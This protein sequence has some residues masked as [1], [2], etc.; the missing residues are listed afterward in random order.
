MNNKLLRSNSNL[1][2]H[3]ETN[4]SPEPGI[5]LPV[6]VN[7]GPLIKEY[8]DQLFRVIVQSINDHKRV[9]ACRFNLTLPHNCILPDDTYTNGPINRFHKSLKSKIEHDLRL[10]RSPHRCRVRYARAREISSNGMPHYHIL[11]LLNLN[12]YNTPGTADYE[13]RNIFRIVTEAWANALHIPYEYAISVVNLSGSNLY[14]NYWPECCH[15]DQHW[16]PAKNEEWRRYTHYYL[17]PRDNYNALPL[18]FERASYL[19][20][21]YS[22]QYGN[23]IRSFETSRV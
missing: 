23:H 20:K 12:V 10:K 11:L 1:S 5:I 14:R 6:H 9:L 17:E 16:Q 2:L 15:N 18:L 21:A 19:C 7:K 3:Y 22:K 4:Y 13:G 8:L